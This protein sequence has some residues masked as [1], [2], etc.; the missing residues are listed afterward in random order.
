MTMPAIRRIAVLLIELVVEAIFLG[1]LLGA[2]LRPQDHW[3]YILMGSIIALPVILA[4]YGYYVSRTL[5]MFVTWSSPIRWHY[6]ALAGTVFIAHVS[7][8]A[9]RLWPD[10]SPE[11]KAAF[12]PFLL[13]G[14]CVAIAVS[15]VGNKIVSGARLKGAISDYLAPEIPANE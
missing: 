4:L 3:F 7:Y 8:L 13:G 5:A 14:T 10:I 6:S 9:F 15:Y 1:V 11:A 12:P 2:S